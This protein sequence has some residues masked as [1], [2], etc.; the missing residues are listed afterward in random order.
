M[1]IIRAGRGAKAQP[2]ASMVAI[3][4]TDP[5]EF[6]HIRVDVGGR[7]SPGHWRN[8]QRIRENWKDVT[9]KIDNVDSRDV[10]IVEVR[11]PTAF[12]QDLLES[13]GV[14]DFFAAPRSVSVYVREREIRDWIGL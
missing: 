5:S 11:N 12:D 6:Q 3:L 9:Y 7:N 10:E 13:T 14:G 4:N 2:G 1:A 8:G